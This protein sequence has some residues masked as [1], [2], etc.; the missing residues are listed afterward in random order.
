MEF[1]KNTI[2]MSKAHTY[3]PASLFSRRCTGV[4]G[5]PEASFFKLIMCWT[6]A[7]YS[8]VPDL[9]GVTHLTVLLSC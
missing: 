1:Q 2:E 9:S 7:F 3:A 8:H 5:T 6:E 4:V